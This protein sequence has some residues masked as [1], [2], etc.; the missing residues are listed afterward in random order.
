MKNAKMEFS[1]L[2]KEWV[3]LILEAQKANISLEEIRK[4]LLSNKKSSQH[5]QAAR[6]HT[7]NPF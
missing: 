3:E 5:I 7:V 2:D 6:S 4:Y 1:Q